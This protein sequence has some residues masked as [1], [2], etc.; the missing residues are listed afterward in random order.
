M[1][2][3]KEGDLEV[4]RV[5]YLVACPQV[6]VTDGPHHYYGNGVSGIDRLLAG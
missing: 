6:V 5:L 1:S 3:V 4:Q 2:Y